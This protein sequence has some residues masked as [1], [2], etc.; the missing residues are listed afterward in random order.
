MASSFSSTVARIC[1]S[2][3]A[4]SLRR[5]VEALLDRRPHAF[6]A[7]LVGQRERAQLLAEAADRA[8][9][10]GAQARRRLALLRARVGEVLADVALD[11]RDLRDDRFEA[12]AQLRR[13]AH[14]STQFLARV[15][16]RAPTPAHKS[17]ADQRG[18]HAERNEDRERGRSR[19]FVNHV[20]ARIAKRTRHGQREHGERGEPMLAGV[21]AAREA[22][23][24][25]GEVDVCRGA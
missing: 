11:V 19:P 10:L 1:S 21:V 9:D 5:Q 13:F 14:R 2:F 23:Q 8:A 20:L 16:A 22:R 15:R 7:L 12:R 18:E 25:G 24:A 4:L 6:E 3:A 17:A